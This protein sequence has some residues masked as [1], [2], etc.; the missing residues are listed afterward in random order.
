MSATAIAEP[1]PASAG[2]GTAMAVADIDLALTHDKTLTE[3]VHLFD[4]RRIDLY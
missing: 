2:P 3:H 4:D 1:G